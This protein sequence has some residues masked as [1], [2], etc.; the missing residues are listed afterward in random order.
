MIFTFTD[1]S[2]GMVE[3]A[4][5]A[6]TEV[7]PNHTNLNFQVED[8]QEVHIPSDSHDLVACMFGY[9]VPDRFKA[10]S[11][12]CRLTKSSGVSVIGTWKY[13][14]LMFM[15]EEFYRFIGCIPQDETSESF[16]LGT[17]CSD[18]VKLHAEL[19][20]S[21]FREITI[22]EPSDIFPIPLSPEF[23]KLWMQNPMVKP[24]L[25]GYDP[26]FLYSEWMKL[27]TQGVLEGR[28]KADLELNVLYVEYTALVCFARK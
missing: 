22:H 11:E 19:I 24:Q 7:L 5:V 23:T 17:S 12:V 4:K 27:V 10:F 16:K 14:G 28:F 2:S 8:V 26:D 15:T 21:G 25:A 13:A 18:P 1:Y 6:V 20:E 9:F 3:A